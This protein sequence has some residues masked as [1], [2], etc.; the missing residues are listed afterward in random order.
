MTPERWATIEKLYHEALAQDTADRGRF[1]ADAC[2]GDEALRR[3]VRSLLEHDGSAAFLSTPA[4]VQV[5]HVIPTDSSLIGK[6]IG[7]YAISARIGAGGMGEVYRARDQKLGR[8]VAIKILS[9]DFTSD[10]ERL[11]RFA[12]EA[13]VLATLNH[14][15]IGAIYGWEEFG[16][17]GALILELVEGETLAER[18]EHGSIPVREA[19]T[20]A[21]QIADA[22][23][24]SHEKDIVHRDLK[25]ANIKINERGLVKVLDFGLAK[26]ASRDM[27]APDVSHSPTIRVTAT[28]E[29][30]L[31][32]T[33][34][35]MS[36]EQARGQAVDKQA[37]IWAFGC[38]LYEMLTGR[39]AFA[40]PTVT[41]TLGAILERDPDWTKLPSATSAAVR[42]L[43]RRCLEK[44]CRVRLHD[45][46]DAR[47][48]LDDAPL[49]G[50]TDPATKSG[51]PWSAWVAIASTLAVAIGL[52]VW[53][54]SRDR[55]PD[56]GGPL[57]RLQINPPDGGR[58]GVVGDVFVRQGPALAL[59]PDG[60]TAVY[61]ATVNGRYALW[62]RSL[63]E[64][65]ARELRG[66]ENAQFPFWSP[67]GRFLAF[68]AN[69][70]LQK[71]DVAGGPPFVICDVPR[72][73]GGAWAPD[74]RILVGILAGPVASVP[75]SGGTLSPLTTLDHSR[76]D[77]AHVWPQ[78]LP[79]GHFL[80]WNAS[81]KVEDNGVIYAASFER[82]NERVRLIAS[83]T[84]AV[85]TSA[86]DGREY[87]LWQ[88][89]GALLAQEFDTRR[90]TFAGEP[91]AIA[92]AIGIVGSAAFIAVAASPNG[93]LLYANATLQRLTLFDRGGKALGTLGDAGQYVAPRFSPDGKQIATTRIEAGR[94]L[95]LIDVDR[96]VSRRATFDSRGGFSPQW[97]PNG[98]TI[99]FMGDN[100]TTLY[101]KDATGAAPDQRLAA[102]KARDAA[103]TDWSRDG[104]SVLNAR[105]ADDTGA[106]I[107]VVPVTPDGHLT[108]DA[109]AKPYLRTPASETA[110]RFS[111][112]P[113]PR[114]VAYQSNESGHAEVY[115]DSFPERRGAHR[116]SASGGTDPQWG[117]GGR[118]LFYRSADGKV[119]ALSLKPE[120]DSL[121]PSAPRELFALPPQSTFEVAPDGQHFL[122]TVP[123]TTAPALNVIVNWP[124]LLK[125]STT[126]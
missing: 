36:P 57:L 18:L 111:P 59:S 3:D 105:S 12:R 73:F 121:D 46:A 8:D 27:S 25:P 67:D 115:V 107:W 123:D 126:H 28:R 120:A 80:Y 9:K 100:L 13:R 5:G 11:A 86:P 102:W 40:G 62:L 92:D 125:S 33:A 116:I 7:P 43:L 118:E 44:D 78:L 37:D 90:L 98:R 47:L 72:V 38:V 82:P 93:T 50:P 45:I 16:G 119:M 89:G 99:L 94:E 122:V 42:R 22:L 29:G 85:F 81:T 51:W 74:D 26:A 2:A 24:A 63:D 65:V 77:V 75:A 10:P 84:S 49:P 58:F 60:R 101:L 113:N 103:L 23:E 39:V 15:H 106:D 117:P 14:P 104:H 56:T 91:R 34:A 112:V 55:Q 70:K 21:R 52:G 41:D 1:L 87:V 95:V 79:G 83:E 4:V 68:F 30:M 109:E 6:A 108:A 97:S 110:G 53:A 19:L 66:T 54:L 35:Y 48:E 17:V 32:G 61:G 76:G 124:S 71:L 31:L 96:R 64:S 88:R 114:W 20:M 69:G